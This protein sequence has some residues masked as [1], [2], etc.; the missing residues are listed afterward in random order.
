MK[1]PSSIGGLDPRKDA[2]ANATSNWPPTSSDGKPGVACFPAEKYRSFN[3]KAV[4]PEFWWA[5]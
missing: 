3:L 1:P 5:A 2:S 4:S